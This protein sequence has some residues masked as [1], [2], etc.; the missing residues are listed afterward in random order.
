MGQLLKPPANISPLHDPDMLKKGSI[1]KATFNEHW[2]RFFLSLWTAINTLGGTS[3][4]AANPTAKVGSAVVNGTAITFMRSDAAPPL[5]LAADY[6]LTGIWNFST[7][8]PRLPNLTVATL[9]AAAVG[10]TGSL[11]YVTDATLGAIAGLG[12]AAIGGGTNKVVV[13]SDGTNWVIL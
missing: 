10:N 4:G 3:G 7:K 13:Y 11:A 12:T 8:P 9:P 1:E 5:D 2:S 6:T